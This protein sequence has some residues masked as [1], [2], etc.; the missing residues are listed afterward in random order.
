M[1]KKNYGAGK[2]MGG[3]ET[4]RNLTVIKKTPEKRCANRA[5]LKVSQAK[6]EKMFRAFRFYG[7]S[8]KAA[9][10]S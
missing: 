7:K 8:P 5:H 3:V 1:P 9:A 10:R 6:N 4:L 2:A